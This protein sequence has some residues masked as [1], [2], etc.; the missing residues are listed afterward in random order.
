MQSATSGTS[1]IEK[2]QPIQLQM[3]SFKDEDDRSG[4]IDDC[5][6]GLFDCSE[7]QLQEDHEDLN[8]RIIG[9]K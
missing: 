2:V 6:E 3:Y 7:P 4:E 8:D 5:D 9:R 1:L